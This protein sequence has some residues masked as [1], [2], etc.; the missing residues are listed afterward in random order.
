MALERYP[1]NQRVIEYKSKVY[2]EITFMQEY[3]KDEDFVPIPV[4]WETYFYLR[5]EEP[6]RPMLEALLESLI[7]EELGEFLLAVYEK[8]VGTE[9]IISLEDNAKVLED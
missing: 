3:M 8:H 5:P 2:I 7:L 1:T 4:E 9:A 6:P